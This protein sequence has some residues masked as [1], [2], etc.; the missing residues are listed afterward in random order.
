[1]APAAHHAR[2]KKLRD[3]ILAKATPT[4][5]LMQVD[6]TSLLSH[7]TVQRDEWQAYIDLQDQ[8]PGAHLLSSYL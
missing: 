6:V 4:W 5:Q 3:A 7:S 2:L 1:M 8:R